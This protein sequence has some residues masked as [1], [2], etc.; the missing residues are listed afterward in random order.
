[1]ATMAVLFTKAEAKATV[2]RKTVSPNSLERSVNLFKR[3]TPYSNIPD[4]CNA[5]LKMNKT[6]IVI[7]A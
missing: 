1:M 7:T 5:W 2:M 4:F 6:A 3:T